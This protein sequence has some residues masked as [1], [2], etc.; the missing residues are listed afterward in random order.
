MFRILWAKARLAQE[1][2]LNYPNRFYAKKLCFPDCAE[3]TNHPCLRPYEGLA[4][5]WHDYA[6]PYRPDYPAFLTALARAKKFELRAILDLACGTGSLTTQLAQMTSEVV[7]LDASESMLAKAR[8]SSADL[9][10]VRYVLGDFRDFQVGQ[11]FDAVVCAFNSVNYVGS[12]DELR[13]LFRAVAEHLRPVGRFVFDTITEAGMNLLNGHYLHVRTRT[14]RF[15]IRFKYDK[16]RRKEESA[17]LLPWGTEMHCRTPIDPK[18]VEEACNGS[19]LVVEDFF[20]SALVPGRWYIG[21]RC[22]FVLRKEVSNT[23]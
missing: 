20:S 21:A 23:R 5:V 22:F 8:A 3:N 15:A 19:G 14:K 6:R 13:A 16:K 17:A 10:G 2:G 12:I 11:L 7:G 1:L 4:E 9:P 18:D